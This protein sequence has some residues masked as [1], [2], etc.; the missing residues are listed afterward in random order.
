MQ[1]GDKVMQRLSKRIGHIIGMM[2]VVTLLV[3]S[4]MVSLGLI[5]M[6]GKGLWWIIQK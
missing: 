4:A 3:I 2:L 5:I 6:V 1:K